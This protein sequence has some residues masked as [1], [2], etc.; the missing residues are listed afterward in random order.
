MCRPLD[1]HSPH[2]FLGLANFFSPVSPFN[3]VDLPQIVFG[4]LH[5]LRFVRISPITVVSLRFRSSFRDTSISRCFV[6][7]SIVFLIAHCCVYRDLG[8]VVGICLASIAASCDLRY[9]RNST[10]GILVWGIASSLSRF[11]QRPFSKYYSAILYYAYFAPRISV[12]HRP[13][14]FHCTR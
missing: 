12:A 4:Q 1:H 9:R 11:A 7:S 5:S 14:N 8:F 3:F 2:H 13:S 6:R 10:C